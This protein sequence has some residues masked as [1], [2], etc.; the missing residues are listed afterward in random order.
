[1]KTNLNPDQPD[2]PTIEDSPLAFAREAERRA[3]AGW[4][5]EFPGIPWSTAISAGLA[6]DRLI[7][8]AAALVR[9][10]KGVV[11]QTR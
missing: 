6:A 4:E 1:M 10:R 11:P 9:E 2:G 8:A 7:Q 5:R 3:V